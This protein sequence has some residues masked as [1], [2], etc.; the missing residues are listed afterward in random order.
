MDP[1]TYV[2]RYHNFLMT[3]LSLGIL[4]W[5]DIQNYISGEYAAGKAEY[6]R[7]VSAAVKARKAGSKLP[8]LFTL[9]GIDGI[10]PDEEFC[11]AGLRRAY[12]GRAATCELRDAVRLAV[13]LGVMKHPVS[14][15]QYAQK[16]FGLDC[17]AFVGNWL[18]VS[19]SVAIFAYFLGYGSGNIPGATASV[20]A[21]REFLPLKPIGSVA[22]IRRGN[23]VITYG[24][25]RNGK[26]HKHIALVQDVTP[27]S[28]GRHFLALAEWGRQGGVTK[29]QNRLHVTFETSWRH[30]QRP[31]VKLVSF[32]DVG[33]QGLDHRFIL[34]H[35]SLD[36]FE[37]R[38]WEVCGFWGV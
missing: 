2:E 32:P 26:Q 36:G 17:N 9:P 38:G 19:P 33:A 24:P 29:H 22:E 30:P 13:A 7:V 37:H 1:Y 27:S 21:S 5:T 28:A 10:P 11:K 20:Y 34:D 16:W 14:S 6:G 23:V 35:S 12:A 15:S 25:P 18:G 8:K 4:G 3:D 31:G